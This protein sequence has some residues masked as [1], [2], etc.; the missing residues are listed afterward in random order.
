MAAVG[1]VAPNQVQVRLV[2]SLW[3]TISREKEDISL[4]NVRYILGGLAQLDFSRDKYLQRIL[5]EDV[6]EPYFE[7][8]TI[9]EPCSSK[10]LP[11][12]LWL[13]QSTSCRVAKH[14][15]HAKARAVFQGSSSQSQAEVRRYELMATH[16]IRRGEHAKALFKLRRV[17][18]G[19]I[20][21]HYLN[22]VCGEHCHMDTDPISLDTCLSNGCFLNL[23][24]WL[25]S[26]CVAS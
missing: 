13:L 26:C 20:L 1:T 24:S 21:P 10:L 9:A 19:E 11:V 6:M 12:C 14:P 7:K 4:E 5:N 15:Q 16:M 18:C 3:L 2:G 25:S 8:V 22:Q 23:F 17:F